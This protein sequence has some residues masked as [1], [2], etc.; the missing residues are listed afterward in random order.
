MA[1]ALL[2]LLPAIAT[3]LILGRVRECK[4]RVSSASV[5]VKTAPPAIVEADVF[6]RRAL[7][8][9][10]TW[11]DLPQQVWTAE[12]Q[13]LRRS[14]GGSCVCP[15]LACLFEGR[16]PALCPRP[17]RPR[18]DAVAAMVPIDVLQVNDL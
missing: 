4:S 15:T 16:D 14:Q 6:V 10:F 1:S 9:L 11:H 7:L 17:I 12:N 18:R 5:D 3:E 8:A 2:D 13:M